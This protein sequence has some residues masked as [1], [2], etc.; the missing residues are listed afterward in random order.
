MTGAMWVALRSHGRVVLVV[1]ELMLI[2]PVVLVG[3]MPL[4]RAKIGAAMAR[5]RKVDDFI[6]LKVVVVFGKGDNI[7][8]F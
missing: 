2:S 1:F 8:S 7:L 6:L 5:M 4:G 3:T